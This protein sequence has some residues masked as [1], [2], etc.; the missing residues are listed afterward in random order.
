MRAFKQ[1][2]LKALSLVALV[3]LFVACKAKEKPEPQTPTLAFAGNPESIDFKAAAETRS[4][5]VSATV[6]GWRVREVTDVPWLEVS[7]EG[8][9]VKLKL[10]ANPE[11]TKRETSIEIYGESLTKTVKV[12][13]LGA[14]PEIL[15]SSSF[16]NLPVS[17]GAVDFVVTTNVKD[18]EVKLPEWIK[19]R[20]GRAAMREFPQSYLVETNQAETSRSANIEVV[21]RGQSN[22][23]PIK[24]LI[25]VT[26][27]GLGSYQAHGTSKLPQDVKIPVVRGTD[28]S[29]E[30]AG[31]DITKAF[32]GDMSTIYHSKWDN[33]ASNYFP[34]TLTLHFGEANDVDYLV[35]HPRQEG[36][37][38][39][40]KVVDIAYTTDGSTWQ[41]LKTHDFKGSGTPTR[42]RF[43]STLRGV[44][45]FR[46]IVRSGH[47]DRQGFASAA[48]IEFYKKNPKSFDYTSLFKDDICTEL[49]DGITEQEILR[50]E[51]EF[52]RNLAYYMYKDRYERE[53]RIAEFKAYPN[54]RIQQHQ[55]KTNPY[56]LL[57]NPTGI[58][59][60]ANE[61]VVIL[62]GDT[63][64]FDNLALYS[65]NLN[66]PGGDG[67]G[68]RKSYRLQRGLNRVKMTAP[69]LLY[70][71]YH[72]E[73]LDVEDKKPI[74]IHFAGGQVNG[75]Y[76][77]EKHQGRWVELLGKAKYAYFD[78]LGKY[79]HMTFPTEKYRRNNANDGPE[80]VKRYDKIVNAEMLLLG[81][82]MPGNTPFKNRMY[83]HVMYHSYMY[84][85]HFHTGYNVTTLDAIMNMN[86]YALWGP[87]HEIGHMNQ[88]RPGVLWKGMTEC[89]VNIKSAYVQT[90]IFG[91]PSR[92]QT[93][94]QD[95]NK[96][97]NKYT[98]AWNSLIVPEVPFT[99]SDV[100]S[101]LVP[102]WQLEL[103]FGKV[104]GDT[105]EY[106]GAKKD[107]FYP[108]LYDY[109][110][111]TPDRSFPDAKTD[112]TK[113]GFYQ[114]EFA[115]TASKISGYD[116]TDFFTRWG[117]LKVNDKEIG[118][119]GNE[120]LTVTQARVDEVKRQIKAIPGVKSLGNMPLEYITDAN[121]ELFRTKPAVVAGS[122]AADGQTLTLS[123]W[124]NAVAYEVREKTTNRLVYVGDGW[125]DK[126]G[127]A[128]KLGTTAK[129]YLPD[130]V[131]W[132]SGNYKLVGVSA[133]GTRVNAR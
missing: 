116:L 87:A 66:K 43:D 5:R 25:A 41:E 51:D 10:T 108:R 93:E 112:G 62:V 117:Y 17:G 53:F 35:Y 29:H 26:Q 83:M 55:H 59:V 27:S 115:L 22:R 85:T 3:S 6:A 12:R 69:G 78:V 118:D 102:F 33:R 46:F 103:Y 8:S 89:T 64:G 56:S 47:G 92:V 16:L 88:T 107:G 73:T 104:L 18:F 86:E 52:F 95:G 111:K 128:V 48:E 133:D 131:N 123:G 122:V 77:N 127:D 9:S 30:D 121:L 7:R 82:Y 76:D 2:A 70:V 39:Y 99:E 38:G 57:D 15:V 90:S 58:Y 68:D 132:A 23:E 106:D 34:I 97:H 101:Q 84:A 74:K 28:S 63:H 54:P 98:K 113:N 49:K 71:S 67:F 4:V 21:E 130:A 40:F 109:Y 42:V 36:H 60:Q 79:V 96:P 24:T 81:L 91:R 44:K 100:F 80:L 1:Y 37:N 125:G 45:G 72:V 114:T 75:Y 120:R 50:C 61:E 14:L 119:Y 129:L 126:E 94:N 13:Q 124:Q 19:E 110:R 65:V 32:D 31:S 105:P 20:P 11:E